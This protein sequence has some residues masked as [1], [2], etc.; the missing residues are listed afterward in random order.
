MISDAKFTQE[1]LEMDYNQ[2]F[3]FGYFIHWI[4]D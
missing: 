4:T 2:V 3:I 1:E